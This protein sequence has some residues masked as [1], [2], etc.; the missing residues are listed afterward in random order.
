MSRALTVVA[1]CLVALLAV[2][3]VAAQCP[4]ATGFVNCLQFAKVGAPKPDERCCSV[5]RSKSW[6]NTCLCNVAMMNI[7]GVNFNKAIGLP[8]A[9]GRRVPRGTKCNGY[10]VP[11]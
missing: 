2:E 7:P 10:Q 9:C 4:S 8:K 11:Y 1:V 5:V 6:T 3:L